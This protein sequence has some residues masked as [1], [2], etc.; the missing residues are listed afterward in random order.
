MYEYD[1]RHHGRGVCG[2]NGICVLWHDVDLG[3]DSFPQEGGNVEINLRDD[4]ERKFDNLKF[5]I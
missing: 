1:H 4:D 3:D 2:S 5:E